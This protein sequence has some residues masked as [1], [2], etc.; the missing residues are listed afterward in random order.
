MII[1]DTCTFWKSLIQSQPVSFEIQ[2]IFE[3]LHLSVEFQT[4]PVVT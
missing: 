1:L 2:A 3:V 4:E